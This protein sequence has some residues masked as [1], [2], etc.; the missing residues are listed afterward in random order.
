VEIFTED[1]RS[2][3]NWASQ[4]ARLQASRPPS[5]LASLFD[6]NSVSRLEI[7]NIFNFFGDDNPSAFV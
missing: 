5:F 6:T 7:K 4:L 1:E 2:G 3:F